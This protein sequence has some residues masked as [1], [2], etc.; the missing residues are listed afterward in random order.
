MSKG[1]S[2]HWMTIEQ[3]QR[4]SDVAELERARLRNCVRKGVADKSDAED[5]LQDVFHELVEPSR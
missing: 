4:I 1:L 5:I 3:D 2:T